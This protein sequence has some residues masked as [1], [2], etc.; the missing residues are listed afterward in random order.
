MKVRNFLVFKIFLPVQN[1]KHATKRQYDNTFNDFTFN[2][3]TYSNNTSSLAN[4]LAT[5]N[6]LF[7]C[8]G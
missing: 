6:L 3:F 4:K 8:Y 5:F 7:Y 1:L 2:I